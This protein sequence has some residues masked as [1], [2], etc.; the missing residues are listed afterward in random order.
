[1]LR[2]IVIFLAGGM[3]AL[4]A[5]R[6]IAFFN[7]AVRVFAPE[8][9][10]GRMT[11][12]EFAT[13]SFALSIGLVIGFGIPFSVM[14]P[15]ILMHTVW[16]TTDIIGTFFPGKPIDN[17]YQDKESLFGAGM[18]ILVGGIYGVMLLVGLEAFMNVMKSLPINVFDSWMLLGNPIIYAF[19]A[20]PCLVVAM[21]YGWKKGLFSLVF[22]VLLRQVVIAIGQ[23]SI[24]DGVALLVGLLIVVFF[25][26]KDK[27]PSE[28]DLSA[29]F[30]NRV[31]N[32][33]K[34]I[35]WFFVMGGI[36]GLAVNI[37][38]I[39]EGPQSLIALIDG[40][41]SAAV[42]ISIARALSFVPLIGLTSI[43]AGAFCVSGFGFV[44]V[45]GLLAPN[46]IVAFIAGGVVMSL[47]ALSLVGVAKIFDK[48][49]GVR[50]S[51]DS[52]R[53]AMTKLLEIAIL[54]GSM[55][56]ADAMAPG[57]GFFVVAGIFVMN[58]YFARPMVRMAV[59]PVGTIIVAVL[60][61]VLAYAGL[62]V[63]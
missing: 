42:G 22:V 31:Q 46:M 20:F 41:T 44:A 21:D 32:I 40:N 14:S 43:M 16:L 3:G 34:N 9:R 4:M 50:R 10:E 58:D 45:A 51:G 17:W 55:M 59:G 27:T 47:E 24:A 57:L 28:G 29:T 15:I 54:V 63:G 62:Y 39:M 26:V 61:N 33:R 12:A 1:M 8:F 5:N 48:F 38:L 52:M 23:S 53:V 25:A 60:V 35:V 19:A 36:Y 56:A 2:F 6:G 13:T 37:S 7:D 11:R 49:P 18:S 30:S